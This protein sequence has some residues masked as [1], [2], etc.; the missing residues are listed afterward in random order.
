MYGRGKTLNDYGKGFYTTTS[1]DLAREWAINKFVGSNVLNRYSITL[2]LDTTE[3]KILNLEDYEP[4][5]WVATLMK[6]RGVNTNP[7]K[8][9]LLNRRDLEDRKIQDFTNKYCLDVENYD[10][11]KGYRADDGYYNYIRAFVDNLL[12]VNEIATIMRTGELGEQ[13]CLKSKKAFS[14]VKTIGSSKV[15]LNYSIMY[16]RGL[17][18][19]NK[20]VKRIITSKR[21]MDQSYDSQNN[22]G[23]FNFYA[24]S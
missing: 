11:I 7:F 10:L 12:T 3:L 16:D 24:N 22:I 4:V 15:P 23:T 13:V 5:H 17:E 21:S 2:E 1:E 8:S 6:H 9:D 20:E 14:M 18:R 19:A